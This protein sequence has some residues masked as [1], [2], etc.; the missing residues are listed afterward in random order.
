MQTISTTLHTESEKVKRF[1]DQC[2]SLEG[3]RKLLETEIREL[4]EQRNTLKR[5]LNEL[6]WQ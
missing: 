5:T 2:Q 1:A 4:Q 3:E 6:Q